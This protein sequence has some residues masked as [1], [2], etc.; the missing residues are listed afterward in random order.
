MYFNI[1][2]IIFLLIRMYACISRVRTYIYVFLNFNTVQLASKFTIKCKRSH[3]TRRIFKS[4]HELLASARTSLAELLLTSY[5]RVHE[6][7][8]LA[9]VCPCTKVTRTSVL[10]NSANT[11]HGT[12][13][14]SRARIRVHCFNL[15][16]GLLIS[17]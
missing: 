6:C 16:S 17:L 7:E 4:V 8:I 3:E 15:S 11:C 12:A 13:T 10:A 14:C 2:L 9:S 1:Y 5:L